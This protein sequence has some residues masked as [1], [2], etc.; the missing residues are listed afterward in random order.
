MH[1]Q[2]ELAQVVEEVACASAQPHPS[3]YSPRS[4]RMTHLRIGVVIRTR[5]AGGGRLQAN[6]LA[7]PVQD[8][9][10]PGENGRVALPPLRQDAPMNQRSLGMDATSAS[11]ACC[12]E[13]PSR[14]GGRSTC[15]RVNRHRTRG[16]AGA[17]IQ[18]RSQFCYR[19]SA[20]PPGGRDRELRRSFFAQACLLAFLFA[21][22][23]CFE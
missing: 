1:L 18:C 15:R 20:R 22:V 8:E 21:D 9:V 16:R 23:L 10:A 2:A 5:G 4:L 3:S 12:T 6:E 14:C 17:P 13:K 7:A 11:S 19:S